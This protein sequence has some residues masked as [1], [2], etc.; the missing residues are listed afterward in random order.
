MR[1]RRR[2]QID[3]FPHAIHSGY[4]RPFRNLRESLLRDLCPSVRCFFDDPFPARAHA[5]GVD[6][7]FPLDAIRSNEE[8]G[9]I[10]MGAEGTANPRSPPVT[11]KRSQIRRPFLAL[12]PWRRLPPSTRST[13]LQTILRLRS[14]G[15]Q[16]G[17]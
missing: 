10:H 7:Y 8:T 16:P 13:I 11:E 12:R 4:R 6:A 2:I 5:I 14:G 3:A 1:R 15:A 9:E 17:R